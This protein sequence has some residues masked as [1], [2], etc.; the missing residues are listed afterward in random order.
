MSA[1]AGY[2]R[3]SLAIIFVVIS[4]ALFLSRGFL[5]S[6]GI[7]T[8]VL[9]AGNTILFMVTIASQWLYQR[10]LAHPKTTGFLKNTYGSILLRLFVCMIAIIAYMLSA[11]KD[12]NKPAIGGCV[13]LYFLYT[14]VEMSNLRQWNKSRRDA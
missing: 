8:T 6:H 13:F 10:A 3:F 2:S 11:G 4:C 5:D 12:V 9:L 1:N 14:L 7:A